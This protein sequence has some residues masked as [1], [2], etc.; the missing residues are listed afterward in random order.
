MGLT[1]DGATVYART[2]TLAATSTNRYT[3]AMRYRNALA[4]A[5]AADRSV[6]WVGD[7]PL[8][9][10]VW[11]HWHHTAA[12]SRQAVMHK[13]STGVVD[14]L[15]FTTALLANTWYHLAGRWDGTNLTLWLNGVQ[16][17]TAA[18]VSP[19]TGLSLTG[20]LWDY[21]T[22]L[23]ETDNGSLA[24][25]TWWDTALTDGELRGLGRGLVSA[26]GT[27]R[28]S[29][30]I[31]APLVRSTYDD[32]GLALTQSGTPAVIAHPPVTGG[33]GMGAGLGDAFLEFLGGGAT[34][35]ALGPITRR[36]RVERYNRRLARRWRT[37]GADSFGSQN[38]E[39][40]GQSETAHDWSVWTTGTTTSN[41]FVV[42][43]TRVRVS[44][45]ATGLHWAGLSTGVNDARVRVTVTPAAVSGSG[46]G[47]LFRASSAGAGLLFHWTGSE[48]R[49][50][51][52]DSAGSVTALVTLAATPAL[53]LGTRYTLEVRCKA[54][55]IACYVDGA[56]VGS[57]QS[58][59]THR[60]NARHGFLVEGHGANV[61]DNVRVHRL[62][63]SVA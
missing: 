14:T 63:R 25:F 47:V 16:D 40:L 13:R 44:W 9:Y 33:A 41:P 26:R 20:T 61:F 35:G 48:W 57:T 59:A 1:G 27:R 23:F 49:L 11:F 46:V 6:F 36:T 42:Y 12:G 32:T 24:E 29:Q 51:Q 45:A 17:S 60:Q 22:G 34:H 15:Q 39:R 4:P 8:N 18:S 38:S 7:G 31:S 58:L 2:G 52:I 30:R 53:A 10:E 37:Y 5:G 19:A 54:D 56:Q 43:D 3:W 28:A 50:S 62:T 21:S 55:R